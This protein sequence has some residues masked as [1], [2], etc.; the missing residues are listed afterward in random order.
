MKNRLACLLSV[1]FSLITIMNC[2]AE[3]R[4]LRSHVAEKLIVG[5]PLNKASPKDSTEYSIQIDGQDNIVIVNGKVVTHNSDT[6]TNKNKIFVSGDGN[7]VN[8]KSSGNKSEVMIHQQGNKNQI[9]IIQNK[10]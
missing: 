5:Y 9:N 10:K 7:E 1:S 2:N 8:I 4:L 6:I 3:K